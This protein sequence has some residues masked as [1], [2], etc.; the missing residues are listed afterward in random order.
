MFVRKREG[1]RQ[2]HF[3]CLKGL[4]WLF[5]NDLNFV[6]HIFCSELYPEILSH[7]ISSWLQPVLILAVLVWSYFKNKSLKCSGLSVEDLVFNSVLIHC[8]IFLVNWDSA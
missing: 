1:E 7:I 6:L 3:Q 5:R 2:F 8:I 4:T